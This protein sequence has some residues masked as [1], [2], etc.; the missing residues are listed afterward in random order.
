MKIVGRPANRRACHAQAAFEGR[1]GKSSPW[2]PLVIGKAP[3][4]VD[5][6]RARKALRVS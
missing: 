3:A 4:A 1:K 6:D 2:F 5:Q